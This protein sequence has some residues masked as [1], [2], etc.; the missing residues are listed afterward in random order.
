VLITLDTVRADRVGACGGSVET[1]HLEAL[2]RR[3]VV[4][5]H[6]DTP[7]PLTGPS[8]ASLFT[9]LPPWRH[10][11]RLNGLNALDPRHPVLAE[12]LAAKGFD[13]AAFVAAFP[14]TR[15][16]G[17]ARGFA[18][19]DDRMGVTPAGAPFRQLPGDVVTQRALDWIAQRGERP[20]FLWVHY[21]DAHAPHEAPEPFA[22]AHPGDPYAGEIAF[23]DDQ[24]G[25]VLDALSKVVADDDL[26]VVVVGD[27]GEGLGDHGEDEHGLLLYEDTLHVPFILAGAGAQAG[28]HVGQPVSLI[29]VRPTILGAF[30][31][32]APGAEGV[33]L[34]PAA[35]GKAEAPL[36]ALHAE[37]LYPQSEFGWSPLRATRRGALKAIDAPA[38]ELY[39]LDADPGER[40]NLSARRPADVDAL[41][42]LA[43]SSGAAGAM[44]SNEQPS[45]ADLEALQSLGYVGAGAGRSSGDS[46]VDP[47][48]HIADYREFWRASHLGLEG[49]PEDLPEAIA[50]F[51]GLVARDPANPLFRFRWAM[52]LEKAGR[53]DEAEAQMREVVRR[54]P[55]WPPA[56][57]RLAS[58]LAS[59]GRAGEGADLLRAFAQANPGIEGIDVALAACL[60]AAGRLDEALAVAQRAA[61]ERPDDADAA[62]LEA[63][64]LAA[65]GRFPDARAAFEHVVAQDPRNARA[66]LGLARVLEHD[67]R[68]DEALALLE[69]T[70]AALPGQPVLTAEACRL[71]TALGRADA[72]R[73]WCA[74]GAR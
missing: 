23:L 72:A 70:L 47:K 42:T 46:H 37:T 12:E 38:K 40:D 32:P 7:V 2:A 44:T 6:A 24:V 41:A 58:L 18:T 74:G 50:A 61:K 19:Y 67:G 56:A 17:F 25:R 65:N 36:R 21:F 13:T 10:G 62:C 54:A 35:R 27:H 43:E 29:D 9:G 64:L 69:R 14:V 30:G 16:F 51:E 49:R 5:D 31:W 8:H 39:D 45:A 26:L 4:F 20:F 48:D 1:P 55:D 34:M 53:L 3:G 11:L 33:D 57:R 73:T 60:R 71:A 28:L 63:E 22:A 59:T 68:P 66:A 52:L 15:P